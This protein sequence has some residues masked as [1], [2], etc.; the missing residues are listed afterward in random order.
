MAQWQLGLAC[1]SPHQIKWCLPKERLTVS[2]K[3]HCLCAPDCN[4]VGDSSVK[5]TVREE[6][7]DLSARPAPRVAPDRRAVLPP[8]AL[9]YLRLCHVPL[10]L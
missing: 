4:C 5:K 1:D 8:K 9:I 6:L 2:T 7:G 10:E 3:F